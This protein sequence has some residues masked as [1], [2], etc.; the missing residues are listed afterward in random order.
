MRILALLAVC[1]CYRGAPAPAPASGPPAPAR[2]APAL[3]SY[4]VRE[5]GML[6]Q[7]DLEGERMIPLVSLREWYHGGSISLAWYGGALLACVDAGMSVS[8]T[9]AVIDLATGKLDADRHRCDAVAADRGSLWLLR[10]GSVEEFATLAKLREGT[11]P[12]RAYVLSV[13]GAHAIAT[14]GATVFAANDRHELA[15]LDPVGEPTP[16]HLDIDE[17]RIHALAATRK[18][19]YVAGQAG[20][21]AFDLESRRLVRT[22]FPKER[23]LALTHPRSAKAAPPKDADARR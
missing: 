7:L 6:V 17:G 14:N 1:A 4:A 23:F 3:E 21:R 20:I 13:A 5:D 9:L 19:L 8:S 10:G 12:D 22:L 18:R 15:A 2:R 16:L 11:P